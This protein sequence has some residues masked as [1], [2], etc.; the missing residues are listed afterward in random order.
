MSI[1]DHNTRRQLEIDTA[2]ANINE[3]ILQTPRIQHNANIAYRML[4]PSHLFV[5]TAASF[6]SAYNLDSPPHLRI[7]SDPTRMLQNMSTL[8]PHDKDNSSSIDG[9]DLYPYPS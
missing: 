8:P 2:R 9:I 4:F 7:S 1:H 5:C 3:R 6:S